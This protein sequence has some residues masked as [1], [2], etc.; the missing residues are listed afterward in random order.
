[1]ER[2]CLIGIDTILPDA[3]LSTD[4]IVR[5][6]QFDRAMEILNELA[7][8]FT[9]DL[10]SAN[11]NKFPDCYYDALTK[12]EVDFFILTND[13]DR[14]DNTAFVDIDLDR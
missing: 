3:V 6:D 5:G 7:E 2:M 8:K 12:S 1:M 9:V 13:S 14:T 4:I 11:T 10:D